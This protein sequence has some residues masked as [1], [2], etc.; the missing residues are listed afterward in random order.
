MSETPL[1]KIPHVRRHP[2]ALL[3]W[4]VLAVLA[5][6]L[7][8]VG[9]VL[10]I[11][12]TVP[13]VLLAAWAAGKG[14]PQFERWLLAHSVFGPPIERWRARGAV[15]RRAK[16]FSTVTIAGSAV[17]MQFVG[18]IPVWLRVA[19]PLILLTVV[20]WLWMRPEA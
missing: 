8:M 2:A 14:W 5:F 4:R 1:P 20:I 13:F 11:M 18:P 7:G 19:L 9:V 10:P 15:S 12:P 16:W 6:A 17:L 3:L